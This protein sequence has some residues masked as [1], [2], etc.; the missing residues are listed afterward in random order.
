MHSSRRCVVFCVLFF[1]SPLSAPAKIKPWIEVQ[2]P[3]FR[4]LTDGGAGG[5]RRVAREFE[6]I[7]AVFET[8]FPAMK[9]DTGSP[10]LIFAPMNEASMKSLA[11]AN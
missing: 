7:R 1:L 11:P 8:A 5:A 4:V 3:H 10:F 6:Q 9:L 2:S